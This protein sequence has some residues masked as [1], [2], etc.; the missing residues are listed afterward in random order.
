MKQDIRFETDDEGVS[1]FVN[2]RWVMDASLFRKDMKIIIDGRR[3]KFKSLM[4]DG[5]KGVFKY[6]K[7][8]K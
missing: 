6:D 2:D 5:N 3:M 8:F 4:L 1:I 7:R